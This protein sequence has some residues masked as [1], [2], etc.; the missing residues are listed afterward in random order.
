MGKYKVVRIEKQGYIP[1]EEIVESKINENT[2]EDCHLHSLVCI[3]QQGPVL[4]AIF[5]KK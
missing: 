2:R 5:E 4:L 1:I 3:N